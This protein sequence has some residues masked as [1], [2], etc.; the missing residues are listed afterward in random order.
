LSEPTSAG[1]KKPEIKLGEKEWIRN[2]RNLLERVVKEGGHDPLSVA[3]SVLRWG[4]MMAVVLLNTVK[5]VEREFGEKG[6][7]L[8]KN[9]FLEHGMKVGREI[10]KY[11]L[12][13]LPERIDR[14]NLIETW[15]KMISW[16]NRNIWASPDEIKVVSEEEGYFD[17]LWCPHQD[18]YTARDCRIQRWIVS[19]IMAGIGESLF[20]EFERRSSGDPSEL[21]EINLQVTDLIPRGAKTCHFRVWKRKK[22]EENVWEKHSEYLEKREVG[23][24]G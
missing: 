22:G 2:Q 8:C 5:A 6:Q 3:A 18:I 7:A 13:L 11:L 20:E 12:P 19:G 23:K 10:S 21:F 4:Q 14:S 24:S 17:I 16:V 9:V 1:G 15:L